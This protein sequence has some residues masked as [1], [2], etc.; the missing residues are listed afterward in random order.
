MTRAALIAAFAFAALA[1]AFLRP[2][3]AIE[4]PA[5]GRSSVVLTEDQW[6][7]RLSPAAFAVL[8]RKGTEPAYT[9]RYWD[10]YE[11]G[12]YRC[13]ACTA[14]LFHSS[15]KYDSRTGWPSF[16]HASAAVVTRPDGART[17]VLCPRCDSHLGHVFDDGPAPTGR[18][19]CINS[20]ALHFAPARR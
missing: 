8:R 2:Q 5:P 11:P 6:R 1:G 7:A 18:R 20:A 4:D 15:D 16:T 19:F 14:P 17:E 3:P 13:A 12:V 10:H 9:G